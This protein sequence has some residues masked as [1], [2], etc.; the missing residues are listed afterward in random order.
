MCAAIVKSLMCATIKDITSFNTLPAAVHTNTCRSRLSV[1]VTVWDTRKKLGHQIA[2]P[3][4]GAHPHFLPLPDSSWFSLKPCWL[5]SRP[6]PPLQRKLHWN[7]ND[8]ET[9][10]KPCWERLCYAWI[11]FF[12][13]SKGWQVTLYLPVYAPSA[14]AQSL[15]NA[16]WKLQ[17][18]PVSRRVWGFGLPTC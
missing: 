10:E 13:C 11:D 5:C 7:Y 17:R 15:H 14:H 1:I 16:A 12:E 4:P 8:D 9:A 3:Q 6:S 2:S 18:S